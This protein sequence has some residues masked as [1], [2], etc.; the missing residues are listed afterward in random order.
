MK[1]SVF[2]KRRNPPALDGQLVARTIAVRRAERDARYQQARC[3]HE[4]GYPL[5]EIASRQ[6]TRD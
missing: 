5:K 4:Q 1:S 3:L 2:L 6:K